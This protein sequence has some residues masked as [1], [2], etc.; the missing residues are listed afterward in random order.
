MVAARIVD[1]DT[2]AERPWNGLEQG[3]L[4][5][6]GPWVARSYYND[7]RTSASFTA[8]GWLRTG[9]VATIDVDGYIRLVDRTKDVIKSG[10]EWIS[11]IEL[12]NEIMAH[13]DV[14]EAAV[15]GVYDERW[16]ERPLA[17]VVAAKDTSVT[18]EGIRSFLDGRIAKWWIPERIELID[19]VPKTSVGKFSKKDLRVRFGTGGLPVAPPAGYLTQDHDA[20]GRPA[21][22]AAPAPELP[23]R[24]RS[25]GN[26]RSRPGERRVSPPCP[27]WVHCCRTSGR[28]RWWASGAELDRVVD[29]R[30][31]QERNRHADPQGQSDLRA[32]APSRV[33]RR[34]PRSGERDSAKRRRSSGRS[35]AG[36]PARGQHGRGCQTV[37]DPIDPVSPDRVV[38]C[39]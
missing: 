11:S 7:E 32:V 18:A 17:C 39:L 36:G 2:D 15:I 29:E 6:T 10:G 24:S 12:E 25:P 26:P 14:V 5:V 20:A 27:R 37:D 23:R 21:D 4:R 3:E 22:S 19:E 33:P 30:R 28:R 13:P 16:G 1:P 34:Q 38:G 31:G 35:A 8:D 9:D